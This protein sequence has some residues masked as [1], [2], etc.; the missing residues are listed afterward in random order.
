MLAPEF[1]SGC[2]Q[3]GE[4]EA[5]PVVGPVAV[6]K[7]LFGEAGLPE[8]T[9]GCWLFVCGPG[10][11]DGQTA[12]RRARAN[13]ESGLIPFHSAPKLPAYGRLGLEGWYI[14]LG[15]D[16]YSDGSIVVIFNG[17]TLRLTSARI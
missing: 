12:Y 6:A 15:Q 4:C 16:H 5:R 8:T 13:G 1:C 9:K 7:L 14:T 10:K 11:K 3:Q 2:L 17:Q